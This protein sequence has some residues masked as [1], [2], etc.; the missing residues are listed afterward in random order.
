MNISNFVIVFVTVVVMLILL[1]VWSGHLQGR[2]EKLEG[3]INALQT[4]QQEKLSAF[5][6]DVHNMTNITGLLEK[7][8][9]ILQEIERRTR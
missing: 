5:S 1:I 7:Q 2:I 9:L 4:L 6:N 3:Q 8:A